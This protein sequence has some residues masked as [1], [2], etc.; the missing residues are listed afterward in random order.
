MNPLLVA[1]L[2][3]NCVKC[4]IHKNRIRYY[5]QNILKNCSY[6][7]TDIYNHYL[8]I[9]SIIDKIKL[10]LFYQYF[11]GE[12]MIS[13]TFRLASNVITRFNAFNLLL[14]YKKRSFTLKIHEQKINLQIYFLLYVCIRY[15][16]FK[17]L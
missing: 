17:G 6:N 9:G 10:T 2:K 12:V 15:Q 16:Y 7:F 5:W 4:R 14:L 1:C 8:L 3:G 13:I 11:K